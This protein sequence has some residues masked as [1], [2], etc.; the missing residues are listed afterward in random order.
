M[1]ILYSSFCISCVYLVIYLYKM[2]TSHHKKSHLAYKCKLFFINNF[3][4]CR[5]KILLNNM[6]K[7][8]KAMR[9]CHLASTKVI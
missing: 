4:R 1:H 9:H 7:Q 5:V 6:Q 3:C 2:Q 8:K